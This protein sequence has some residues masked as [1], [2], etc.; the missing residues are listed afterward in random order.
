LFERGHKQVCRSCRI[1]RRQGKTGTTR[2]RPLRCDCGRPAVTVL[3]RSVGL[4]G[5]YQVRLPVCEE[6]KRLEE[7]S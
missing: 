4:D 6:C 1:R 3:I 7:Q 2:H 5:V